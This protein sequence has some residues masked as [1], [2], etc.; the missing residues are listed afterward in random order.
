MVPRSQANSTAT[1][2]VGPGSSVG[3]LRAVQ[4]LVGLKE[5][6]FAPKELCQ[7]QVYLLIVNNS[8]QSLRITKSFLLSIKFTTIVIF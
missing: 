3:V 5:R 4:I 8:E 1:V 7:I 6:G 2:A